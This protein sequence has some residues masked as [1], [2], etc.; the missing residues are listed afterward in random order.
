M[1]DDTSE[2]REGGREVALFDERV[3]KEQS[4]GVEW[5]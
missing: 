4:R 1:R 3:E 2:T 5:S